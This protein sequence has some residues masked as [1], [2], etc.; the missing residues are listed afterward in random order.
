[1]TCIAGIQLL[2]KPVVDVDKMQN[3]WARPGF[4]QSG[5][6]LVFNDMVPSQ[7]ER[8]HMFLRTINPTLSPVN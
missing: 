4:S 2:K 7:L 8:F 5:Q 1:M 6:K 3:K